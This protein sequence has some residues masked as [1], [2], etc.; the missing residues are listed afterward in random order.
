[1]DKVQNPSNSEC[2]TPSSEHLQEVLADAYLKLIATILCNF[3]QKIWSEHMEG[4]GV[5]VWE[6]IKMDFK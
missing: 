6:N 5:D 3:I 1:M 2:Y 4:I